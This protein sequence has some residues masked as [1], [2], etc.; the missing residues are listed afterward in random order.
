MH[1][2]APGKKLEGIARLVMENANGFNTIIRENEKLSKAK[3]IIDE[4]EADV[5]AYAEHRI[6]FRHK[7]N[8]N[9]LSQMFRGGEAEIQTVAAHNVNENVGRVQEGG[10]SMLLHGA[11]MEQF[12]FEPSSKDDTGLGRWAVMVF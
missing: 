9:G 4:L 12:D 6:N 3:E 2:V 11:L 8:R 7:Q 1:G 10:T 5:V